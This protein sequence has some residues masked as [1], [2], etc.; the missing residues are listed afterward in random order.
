[1][2]N[3]YRGVSKLID[4][5]GK[6]RWRFRVKGLPPCYVPGPY[7]S[8]AFIAAWEAAR[9]PNQSPAEKRCVY[10]TISAMIAGY[11]ESSDFKML[12]KITQQVYRRVL[13]NFREKNGDKS[14]ALLTKQNI[15]TKM[16]ATADRPGATNQFLKTLRSLTKYACNRGILKSDPTFGI[17]KLKYRTKGFHVWSDDEL[18][19]FEAHYPIGTKARLAYELLITTSQRRQT[20]PMLGPKHEVDG[21]TSL[22]FT[23][24]KT[25]EEL[26]LPI[27]PEL[28]EAISACPIVGA[29]TY[30]VTG[31]G[32]PFSVNGFGNWFAARCADA[33][34]KGCSAHGVR[35]ATA[36]RMA[37]HGATTHEIMSITGHRTLSEVERY[38]RSANQKRLA[39][40]MVEKLSRKRV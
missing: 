7:G 1:M 5:H 21:G 4:R 10:G 40:G 23:Q 2:K 14:V 11:Y 19:A 18:A 38:T 31:Y 8:E 37:D 26:V 22:K 15:I 30:L 27:L 24:E 33:N 35:K 13:E 16:D 29:E 25:G 9:N 34:L 6:V 28:R 17:K 39:R 20:V 3:R 36:A 32:K 12:G